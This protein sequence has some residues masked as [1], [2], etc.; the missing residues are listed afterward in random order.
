[1][2]GDLI[3][4]SWLNV[5]VGLGL[6]AVAISLSFIYGFGLER[7][8]TIGI[9]RCV[10]QMAI[11]GYVLVYVF[12]I[13]SM[14]IIVLMLLAMGVVA[15]LTA[16]GRLK[17]PYPGAFPIMWLSITISSLFALAYVT[18]ITMANPIALTPRYIVPL[19]GMVIGNTLNG[20][21]LGAERF[22][23]ELGSQRDRIEVLLSLGA[24]STRAA[25]DCVKAAVSAGITPTINALM[26]I[27]LVQIPGIMSGQV[28]SGVDPLIA[29]R[30]QL[31]IM[32][33]LVG[34]KVMA[35]A[36]AIRLSLKKYFTPEHQLRRELL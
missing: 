8:I 12:Q 16:K 4:V 34:G 27:G 19:G 32:F 21:T 18:I 25:S 30:Y 20:I 6:V 10:I 9:V 22:R 7:D 1:M 36:M 17:R 31:I 3:V 2:E 28:L 35:L 26:I 23:S 24:D 29:A 15:A 33:M 5:F 11:L 13:K 14:W